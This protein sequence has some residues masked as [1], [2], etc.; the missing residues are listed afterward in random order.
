[1]AI[2]ID[3]GTHTTFNAVFNK[4]DEDLKAL[5]QKTK[6]AT[7]PADED[8]FPLMWWFDT[9]HSI[10]KLR[11]EADSAWID[12]LYIDGENK[13]YTVGPLRISQTGDTITLSHDGTDVTLAW[14]DGELILRTDEGTN[15]DTVVAVKGKGSG[16][17]VIDLYDNAEMKKMR[18]EPPDNLQDNVT[19]TWP[20]D[21][22]T[23]GYG[24]TTNG[25]GTLS[26]TS[27]S[28]NWQDYTWP[29]GDGNSGDV[30]STNGTATLA[31]TSPSSS[32]A[33][34]GTICMFGGSSTPSGWLLCDG[35][36][37]SRTVYADLFAAIDETWGEGDQSTTFNVPDLRGRGPIGAG[38]GSGLTN[39]SLAGTGGAETH[40]LTTNE[41]P[42]HNHTYDA[43][44]KISGGDDVCGG[45]MN[46]ASGN[47]NTGNAGSDSAHNNM[48]PWAGV[49]FIIKT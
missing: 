48:Q 49:N 9:T 15:T 32:S 35:Q 33:P 11:N 22:G 30:L 19:Y 13:L 47:Y 26:W 12:M 27:V 16:K 43:V 6:Q 23:D 42:Q 14:N 34:A 24:L 18:I 29:V 46:A 45:N 17:G 1:M 4:I 44:K 25:S 40:Q 31:W 21:A 3:S 5:V 37:Y 36:A 20:T 41:M 10:L 7:T 39:R 28:G 2:G 8:T 38:Q